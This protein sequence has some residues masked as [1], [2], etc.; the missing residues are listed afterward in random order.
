MFGLV[1]WNILVFVYNEGIGLGVGWYFME[2]FG[3][4]VSGKVVV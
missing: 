2:R 3:C 1:F 4:K